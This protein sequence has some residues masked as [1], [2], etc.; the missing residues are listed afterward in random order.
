MTCPDCGKPMVSVEYRGTSEDY[1]GTSEY[2]CPTDGCGV[3]IGRW[4]GQRLTTGQI[5]PR[6]GVKRGSR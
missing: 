5:E 1:D 2:A 3:R 6:Y 4:T